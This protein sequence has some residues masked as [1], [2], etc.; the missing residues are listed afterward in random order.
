MIT[1]LSFN[2]LVFLTFSSPALLAKDTPWTKTN[3]IAISAD[4]N[5]NADPDDIGATPFTLAVLAVL[6]KARLQK[7]LVHYD[8]NNFME[9]KPIA[10]ENNEMWRGAIGGQTRWGFDRSKFFDVAQNPEAPIKNLTHEI[11][12]STADN[13]LYIIEAGPSELIY[14]ALKAANKSA[15]DHVVLVSHS[16]YNDY[17]K[18]RP[19]LRNLNDIQALVPNLTYLKIPDQNAELRTKGDYAP[20]HWLRDHADPNLQWVF[21][22]MQKGLPDVS[23]TGMIC[24]LIGLSGKD[25]K[26]TIAELTEWFGSS[27]IPTNGGNTDAPKAPAG[28]TP[29]I[30]YPVT[31]SIF[32]EVDGK[33]VIEAESVP[34]SGD[35]ILDTTEKGYTGKGYLRFMPKYIHAIVTQTRG[36]LTYKLRARL[37]ADKQRLDPPRKKK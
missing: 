1:F 26:I 23:D 4:G 29:K 22:R 12:Q 17:Y 28:V 14:Q 37:I 18:P 24:W 2:A 32:Q 31:E 36:V 19:W 8:F 13:P 11:N 10:P 34:L 6:A 21:Q 9:Y 33:I 25:Q 20:W 16:G 15:R 27:A 35:W 30:N 7:N 3:R 5:P